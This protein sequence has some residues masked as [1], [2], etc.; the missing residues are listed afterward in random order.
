[1]EIFE[2]ED[3]LEKIHRGLT[4]LEEQ[5]EMRSKLQK[6]AEGKEGGGVITYQQKVNYDE[7]G[8]IAYDVLKRCKVLRNKNVT[9]IKK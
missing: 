5:E 4:A 3:E 7:I 8:K 6:E 2:D 1:M 9:A